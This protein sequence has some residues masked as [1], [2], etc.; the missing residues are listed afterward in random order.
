V[1]HYSGV[2]VTKT[3]AYR[4]WAAQFNYQFDPAS[5]VDTTKMKK[6]KGKQSNTPLDTNAG[7]GAGAGAGADTSPDSSVLRPMHVLL[8]RGNSGTQS[9]F[10]ASTI[11]T[12]KLHAMFPSIFTPLSVLQRKGTCL[13][14][15]LEI[16]LKLK[17][18]TYIW[19]A[20]LWTCIY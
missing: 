11:Y 8:G 12:R 14:L 10:L 17:E 1:V 6:K 20:F 16:A 4:Q 13:L 15:L 19:C 2:E 7:A 5:L 3:A 18:V 9:A